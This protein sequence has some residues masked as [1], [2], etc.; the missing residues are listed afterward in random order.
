LAG[1]KIFLEAINVLF[2]KEIFSFNFYSKK[3][4]IVSEMEIGLPKDRYIRKIW[5]STDGT[6]VLKKDF[7]KVF[8]LGTQIKRIWVGMGN[9]CNREFVH[10]RYCVDM[11]WSSCPLFFPRESIHIISGSF[12]I[13]LTPSSFGM[14]GETI[15]GRNIESSQK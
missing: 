2:V 10:T 8:F 11:I 4:Y 1:C 5:T 12:F 13:T 14:L 3:L 7:Q 6:G 15:S 9:S